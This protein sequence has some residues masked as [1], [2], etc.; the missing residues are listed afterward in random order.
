MASQSTLS[1]KV[2]SVGAVRRSSFGKMTAW[3]LFFIALFNIFSGS[4]WAN[5]SLDQSN[6]DVIKVESEDDGV[7]HVPERLLTTNDSE[8]ERD[9]H[10]D[11]GNVSLKGECPSENVSQMGF[12]E[13]TK[14]DDLSSQLR[15]DA[16]EGNQ[17]EPLNSD[18]HIE[19]N[20]NGIHITLGPPFGRFGG[21]KTVEVDAMP[22][23]EENLKKVIDRICK[24][25]PTMREQKPYVELVQTLKNITTI[26]LP[27]DIAYDLWKRGNQFKGTF[28]LDIKIPDLLWHL[29]KMLAEDAYASN[30]SDN[31]KTKSKNYHCNILMEYLCQAALDRYE[32]WQ[33]REYTLEAKKISNFLSRL[34]CKK[35]KGKLE[36]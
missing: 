30:L 33:E 24:Y 3:F 17:S 15:P 12:L 28:L 9:T 29:A 36:M 5:L 21:K 22:L 20:G 1:F 14:V 25:R 18:D 34:N 7:G 8:C 13:E 16:H 6:E 10:V 35:T 23:V 4:V 2:H 31:G 11:D 32:T 27:A 26:E 19:R